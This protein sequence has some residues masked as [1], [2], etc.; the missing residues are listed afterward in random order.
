MPGP[1]AVA[2]PGISPI[3]QSRLCCGIIFQLLVGRLGLLPTERLGRP[4]SERGLFRSRSG[5]ES[6]VLGLVTTRYPA[7]EDS[8][9]CVPV[10]S[11]TRPT[12]W[13]GETGPEGQFGG[14]R[15]APNRSEPRPGQQRYEKKD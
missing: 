1:A 5:T 14:R 2:G 10:R 12:A 3:G 11:A 13:V 15:K 9:G 8:S 6:G 4:Q 7:S